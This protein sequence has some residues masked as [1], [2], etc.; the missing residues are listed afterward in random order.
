M[1]KPE[2]M[3]DFRYPYC[4]FDVG[5]HGF[6]GLL[7]QDHHGTLPSLVG[8]PLRLQCVA[9]RQIDDLFRH[10]IRECAPVSCPD[11]S[12]HHIEAGDTAGTSHAISI[13]YE[14]LVAKID[15]RVTLFE[16]IAA[17]PV[18][19]YGVATQQTGTRQHVGAHFR[20]AE[21]CIPARGQ[22]QPS[23]E[24][25]HFIALRIPAA[26]DYDRVE[27]LSAVVVNGL[28]IHAVAAAPGNRIALH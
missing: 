14:H 25:R 16:R 15:I 26:A 3:C 7:Q 28:S 11:V 20:R 1:R 10:F 8:I 9:R 17:M 24:L 4:S 19:R 27:I 23:L 21:N 22:A 18:N 2:R 12:Q 6:N 5:F 13:D